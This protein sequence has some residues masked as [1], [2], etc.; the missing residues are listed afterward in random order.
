[1]HQIPTIQPFEELPGPVHQ[2]PADATPLDFFSLLWAPSFFQLLAE[3]TN[4]Y[5]SQRLVQRPDNKWHP[6]TPEEI[7]AFLGV[8]IIMGIDQKPAIPHYWSTDPYLGNPGIQSVFPRERF[9]ALN[10]Y[11]HLNDSEQM[12]G[13]DD[14]AY[15]PLYKIRPLID[16]CQHNFRDQYV[17]GKDMSV[18]E[19]MVKFKG[20][21]FF[22]QYMPKKPVKYG[23]KVWM[24]ADSKTGYVSNYDIYLGKPLT[25]ARGEV[26]LATNVVLNLTE[27][28]QHCNRHIYFDNFFTSVKLVEE[29]LRRGTYA[30]GTLR[31]NRY[32]DTYKAKRG[33]RMQGIKIKSGETHQLQKGTML[34]TLWF[35]KR[36]VAVLSSNCNPDERITVQ[37]RVKAAPHVKDVDIPTP[38]NLYHRSMGG[39]DLNDQYRSYY[40]SG[41]SG[42]K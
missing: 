18:D 24:A 23:I 13:C 7:K 2:L 31:A 17:P 36:Q 8:N 37:R 4:R 39:V 3:E 40:P 11:L 6:T 19:G 10:R 25:S 1:M 20:R 32:P 14:A 29:L 41:R 15:D 27:P 35:D 21:L 38:I 9:E 42:K 22:K 16:N 28:F 12:P 33:G 5:A 34:V 26:G 30:C